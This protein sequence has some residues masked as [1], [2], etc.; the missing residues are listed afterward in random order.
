MEPM[1]IL[2]VQRD[3]WGQENKVQGKHG[4]IQ[5][6]AVKTPTQIERLITS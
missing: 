1:D 3:R 6:E 5:P 4:Q 2:L